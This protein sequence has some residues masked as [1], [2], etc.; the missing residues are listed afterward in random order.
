MRYLFSALL[1]C[2]ATCAL[3]AQGKFYCGVGTEFGASFDK[4]A[5]AFE[6]G[7]DAALGWEFDRRFVLAAGTGGVTSDREGTTSVPFFLRLRSL[8]MDTS[9]SPLLGLDLGYAVLVPKTTAKHTEISV[10]NTRLS[11]EWYEAG[12]GS[13]EEYLELSGDP[14]GENLYEFPG[15]GRTYLPAEDAIYGRDGLFA[16]L[17]AG[18]SFRASAYRIELS[19]SLAAYQYY[20][21]HV[22]SFYDNT[23]TRY[24]RP[25]NL[26][27]GSGPVEGN[28]VWFHKDG[29]PVYETARRQLRGESVYAEGRPGFFPR[30]RPAVLVKLGV[31]F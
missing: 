27:G 7:L 26:N 24:G 28:Y 1:I 2:L 5:A 13:E 22:V 23:R 29:T 21:G 30:F 16:S 6:Y 8:M 19:V 20:K 9:V 25:V 17:S 14:E 18:A 11:Y 4:G 3:H 15:G 12:Y 10:N 31:S